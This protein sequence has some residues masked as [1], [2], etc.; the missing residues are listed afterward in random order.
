MF[1]FACCLGLELLVILRRIFNVARQRW[2][3]FAVTLFYH[4]IVNVDTT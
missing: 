1:T 4:N 3:A 2:I